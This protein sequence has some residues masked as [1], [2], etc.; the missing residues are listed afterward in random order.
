MGAMSRFAAKVPL[1][2]IRSSGRPVYII[3]ERKGELFP[4]D[5]CYEALDALTVAGHEIVAR[6]GLRLTICQG[7]VRQLQREVGKVVGK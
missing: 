2:E 6:N 5:F 1:T 7:C 3:H 4:C